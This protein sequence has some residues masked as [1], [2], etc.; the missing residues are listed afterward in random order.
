M[1]RAPAARAARS[2]AVC[3]LVALS[4]CAL[5][6][7]AQA[8]DAP[9]KASAGPHTVLALPFAPAGKAG[10]WVAI[11]GA[12]AVIDAVAQQ[13]RDSFLTLKQ[14]DAV[15]RR[16]G[17]RLTDPS[18]QQQAQSLA[19]ALGADELFTGTVTVEGDRATVEG[20]RS[21]LEAGV[22]TTL[23]TASESGPLTAL[24]ALLHKV[25]L[26]LAGSSAKSA[27]MTASVRALEQASRCAELLDR[28]SI[29]PRAIPALSAA[30]LDTV[31]SFCT[32]AISIDPAFGLAHAYQ[33]VVH[34]LR[35]KAA[36]AK[37]EAE[38]SQP[39]GRWVPMGTL[40]AWFAARRAG[41][42]AGAR[43][44]LA[45]GV[46]DHPGF[47][48]AIGYLAEE[49]QELGNDS[50][51]LGWWTT[52]LA[53]SPGHPFATARAARTLAKLGRK[54]E[55]VALTQRALERDP[56]DAELQIELASRHLDAGHG[57]EAERLFLLALA[58]RPPRPLA[59]LRLGW[60][61]LG[62]NKLE[63]AREHL[64]K[65]VE[66]AVGQDEARTRALAWA[67]L[68][69]LAGREGDR[70]AAIEAL[71]A[72]RRANLRKLPCEAPELAR[73]KGKA[74]FDSVCEPITMAPGG[75]GFED[76]DLVNIDL[77]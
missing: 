26:E 8:S 67:D 63:L 37:R 47:L 73:W 58:Q 11:A 66:L 5:P 43:S 35:G 12:E 48:H 32:S 52:Y 15:L 74:D 51:T 76:A 75:Q 13:N 45:L 18:L 25:A 7:R 36:E 64:K 10:D 17:L 9:A 20:R 56:N 40:A 23:K 68:A 6:Q 69:Q 38:L 3:A 30:Q 60:L 59:H 53:R 19:R 31:E 71:S 39:P 24:P 29:A 27:P 41:D 34:S 33:S 55:A 14:L 65:C 61:Y 21:R 72:A 2:R 62:Q 57:P 46:M 16:R 49:C 50:C 22:A 44:A 4:L 42:L 77:P 54:E 28:Q 1:A 70:E